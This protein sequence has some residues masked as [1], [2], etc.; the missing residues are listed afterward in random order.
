M[1]SSGSFA[2]KAVLKKLNFG[3]WI[4]DLKDLGFDAQKIRLSLDPKSKI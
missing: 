3:F 2:N 4:V 1:V